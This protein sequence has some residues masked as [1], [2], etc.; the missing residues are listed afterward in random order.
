MKKVWYNMEWRSVARG[1]ERENGKFSQ[2]FMKKSP[3]YRI[4]MLHYHRNELYL[5]PHDAEEYYYGG[6]LNA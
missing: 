2:T 6:L 3:N 1:R 4:D 5:M